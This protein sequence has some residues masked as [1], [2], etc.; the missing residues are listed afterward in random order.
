[1]RWIRRLIGIFKPK[2]KDATHI[3]ADH[4]TGPFESKSKDATYIPTSH[5]TGRAGLIDLFYRKLPTELKDEVYSYLWAD[6][7]ST[8]DYVLLVESKC[9]RR[10]EPDS[11]SHHTIPLLEFIRVTLVGRD[12]AQGAVTWYYN[13]Q[14]FNIAFEYFLEL[15]SKV[16]NFLLTD[17]FDVGITP[18]SS[19]LRK[20]T[21]EYSDDFVLNALPGIE[22]LLTTSLWQHT[23]LEFLFSTPKSEQL[24]EYSHFDF[25]TNSGFAIELWPMINR[26]Q[27]TK[28]LPIDIIYKHEG[29][30]DLPLVPLLDLNPAVRLDIFYTHCMNIA[31]RENPISLYIA[32]NLL[33]ELLDAIDNDSIDFTSDEFCR[34][35]SERHYISFNNHREKNGDPHCNGLDWEKF[36]ILFDLAIEPL[37]PT[38]VSPILSEL[39]WII[40]DAAR[41]MMDINI[42]T[43]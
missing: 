40:E 25:M 34:Y 41:S 33:R 2:S 12:F 20:L 29:I 3:S 24:L 13:N 8:D 42:K 28:D 18:S 37:Q 16:S 38:R 19:R 7:I 31:R 15:H 27:G 9:R 11:S 4:S 32:V 36:M 5:L 10:C 21:F 1:M 43:V 23:K 6:T 30:G 26:V 17:I 14:D 35:V 22:K 39:A